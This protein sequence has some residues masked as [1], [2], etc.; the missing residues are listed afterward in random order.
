MDLAYFRMS[1]N[2]PIN[3]DT[4]VVPEQTPKIILDIKSAVC[5]VNNVKDTK[6]NRQVYRRINFVRNGEE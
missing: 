5:M 3:K 4:E 6:H 2:D 1:S